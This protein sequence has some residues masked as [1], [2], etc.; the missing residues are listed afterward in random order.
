L[1]PYHREDSMLFPRN[2]WRQHSSFL[3]STDVFPA[4]PR[5]QWEAGIKAG[6]FQVSGDMP[7]VFFSPG[8]GIHVRKA[9]G[10]VFSLRM[11]YIYG[12]G[13]GYHFRAN[14][15]FAKNDAWT[16]KN[17]GN[18][19]SYSAPEIVNNP[20]SGQRVVSSKTG[21]PTSAFDKVYYNYKTV[22]Q[23]L[24]IQGMFSLNNI[25]FH[26]TGGWLNLYGFAGIGASIY[27]TKVDALD[28]ANNNYAAAFNSLAQ[29]SYSNRKS[30]IRNLRNNILNGAFETPAENH[31]DRRPKL[32]GQTLKP[33]GMV[34]AGVAFRLN[35]RIN[36][37]I[38]ERWTFIKDDLL[39]GQ[40]WQEHAWG[41]AAHTRDFDS[42]NFLSLG[43]NI[44]I[45]HK[46]I[47]PLWWVNPLYYA[48]KELREPTLG[49][50]RPGCS[51]DSD[52]DGIPD[53][54][55]WE[56]TPMGCP[57]D[58]H[59]VSLDTDG[60]GV[61]DCKDYE[62]ITPTYC[63]PSNDKG[64]GKCPCPDSCAESLKR[65]YPDCTSLPGVF[66]SVSFTKSS[67]ALSVNARLALDSIASTL[68]NNPGCRIVL[69]GGACEEK[70]GQVSW[71]RV[72]A[73]ITYLHKKMI[74]PGRIIVRYTEPGECNIIQ[75]RPATP[76][77]IPSGEPPSHPGIKMKE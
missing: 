6:L 42:Y 75:F 54:F 10:Y 26:K 47:E 21:L 7:A 25:R 35:K 53:E 11:E 36:L 23:D 73:V 52:G 1:V 65:I 51:S 30:V 45:G 60:D 64:V 58:A 33:S 48:Y 27:D 9:I 32:F 3:A 5:H 13:R 2:R 59:G 15:N 66:P 61:P 14:E 57:V 38:E 24:S 43:L 41:D 34:G 19:Q 74:S 55:D 31:G 77:D 56:Q 67:V 40:R 8:F 4:K 62:L 71:D 69:L 29:A 50:Y 46:A 17:L 22:V 37:A 49:Q 28:D 18:I 39:D 20:G 44:N 72:N 70:G 68:L 76:D 16:N 12:T 63:Q